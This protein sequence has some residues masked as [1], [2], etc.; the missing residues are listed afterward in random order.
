M[1]GGGMRRGGNWWW[2]DEERGMGRKQGGED[3]T[4]KGW[5]GE[6]QSTRGFLC[7]QRGGRLIGIHCKDRVCVG[8]RRLQ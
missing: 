2:G 4:W 1:I 8:T 6:V 5:E 7:A 3:E